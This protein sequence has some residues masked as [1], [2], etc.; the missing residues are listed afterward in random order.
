MKFTKKTESKFEKFIIYI[1]IKKCH[2]VSH[3]VESC[4]KDE[5]KLLDLFEN[6]ALFPDTSKV[7]YELNLL[8]DD[9]ELESISLNELNEKLKLLNELISHLIKKSE[10]NSMLQSS[11]LQSCNLEF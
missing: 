11:R 9:L 3:I 5:K 7:I 10:Y 4:I 1:K 2:G 6:N 8:I